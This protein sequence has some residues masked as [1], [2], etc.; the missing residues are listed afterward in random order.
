MCIGKDSDVLDIIDLRS[1][2]CV[3]NLTG[4]IGYTFSCDWDPNGG[5]YLATGNEDHTCRIFDIRK[6]DRSLYVL[7]AR[8]A[9]V[10]N[11][12]FSPD[13]LILAVMEESDFV[14]LYDVKSNFKECSTIDLFGETSGVTFS[15]DSEY[16][17]IGCSEPERGGI[18][19]FR[20]QPS[21]NDILDAILV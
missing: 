1:H 9:A 3:M 19:E 7:P 14:T 8:M 5:H 18:F 17:Y 21:S 4:H 2:K 15:P 12:K 10:R 16:F 6:S 13:S 20:R 11:V